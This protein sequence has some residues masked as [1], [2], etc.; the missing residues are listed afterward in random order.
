[1]ADERERAQ[2][3]LPHGGIC[4]TAGDDHGGCRS[5]VFE[6][7]SAPG[8]SLA[9]LDAASTI[10][11]RLAESPLTDDRAMARCLHDAA[12]RPRGRRPF[13]FVLAEHVAPPDSAPWAPCEDGAGSAAC[14]E[15]QALAEEAIRATPGPG[16]DDLVATMADDVR[17]YLLTSAS[18]PPPFDFGYEPLAAGELPAPLRDARR[19]GLRH[20][21]LTAAWDRAV[22][23]SREQRATDNNLAGERAVSLM[24]AITLGVDARLALDL[25]DAAGGRRRTRSW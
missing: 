23:L 12:H 11:G 25:A 1:M 2:L 21:A 8:E 16:A 9:P 10:L 18:G 4:R 15:C 19:V 7:A 13:W 3:L 5:P 22:R 6:I 20:A 17:A 24:H 14:P